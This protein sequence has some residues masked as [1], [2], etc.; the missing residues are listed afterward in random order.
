MVLNI[1]TSNIT[2]ESI[3]ACHSHSERYLTFHVSVFCVEF[4]SAIDLDWTAFSLE[5]SRNCIYDWV[6][7][8]EIG[9]DL[10][11]GNDAERS[12]Y[13]DKYFP[14]GLWEV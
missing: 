11:R 4:G 14:P 12:L 7:T 8:Y 6:R 3:V 1:I 9:E 10:S 2:A 13:Y 5:N